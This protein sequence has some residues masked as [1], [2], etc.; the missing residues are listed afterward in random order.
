MANAYY[1]FQEQSMKM[2]QYQ[3]QCKKL[4]EDNKTLQDANKKLTQE[5]KD[6]LSRLVAISL[7]NSARV[8]IQCFFML[9]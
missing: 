9:N 6:L 3:I 5:K 4:Y 7:A 2:N 8:T 1:N